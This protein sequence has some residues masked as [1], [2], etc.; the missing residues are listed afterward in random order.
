MAVGRGL[1]GEVL[2][3]LDVLVILAD[4]EG[5]VDVTVGSGEC[6]LYTS[7]PGGGQL[8]WL[9]RPDPR[10]A[11]KKA[12]LHRRRRDIFHLGIMYLQTVY[13]DKGFQ[14]SPEE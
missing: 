5:G 6:L 8:P 12:G 2:E 1:A 10:G 7:S 11:G 3:A 14:L 13:K 4:G 9:Y